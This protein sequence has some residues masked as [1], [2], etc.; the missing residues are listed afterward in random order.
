MTT[1]GLIALVDRLRALP[2]ET[3]WCEFKRK[4]YE[5]QQ[6]GEYLS[7]LANAASLAGQPRS[8]VDDVLLSKLPDRLTSKQKQRKVHNLLQELRRSGSIVNRGTRSHPEWMAVEA[9]RD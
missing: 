2:K 3:E 5:P 9:S 7:A 1:G 4:N 6:L 8:A